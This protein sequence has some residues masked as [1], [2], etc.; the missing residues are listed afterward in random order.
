MNF[1]NTPCVKFI[2]ASLIV[3]SVT[4]F[5]CAELMQHLAIVNCKFSFESIEPGAI[6]FTSVDLVVKIKVYNPNDIDVIMDHFDFDF[7]INDK[8]VFDGMIS[9]KR[10]IPKY[11]HIIVKQV[12]KVPYSTAGSAIKDLI[13]NKQARYRITGTAHFETPIGMFPFSVDIVEGKI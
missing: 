7:F 13:S 6:G 3:L 8:V 4:F 11:Q 2:L 9:D 10:T 1:N 12:V 5:G